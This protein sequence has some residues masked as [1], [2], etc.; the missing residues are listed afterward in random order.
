MSAKCRGLQAS[1]MVPP[2]DA[3]GSYVP[4]QH[5]QQCLLFPTICH[6]LPNTSHHLS[7][8]TMSSL[9]LCAIL[10]LQLLPIVSYIPLCATSHLVLYPTMCFLWLGAISHNVPS[11]I[12]CHPTS[13]LSPIM[14]HFPF[15]STAYPMPSLPPSENL[16]RAHTIPSLAQNHS[17][18]EMLMGNKQQTP[19]NA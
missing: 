5:G 12:T 13:L 11:P 2:M 9:Q 17:G 1:I 8:P 16:L 7:S 19:N 6:L 3:Q 10:P 4:A 15:C 14:S 18:L